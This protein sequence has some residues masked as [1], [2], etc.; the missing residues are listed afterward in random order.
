MSR[1][2]AHQGQYLCRPHAVAGLGHQTG[3]QLYGKCLKLHV[4]RLDVSKSPDRPNGGHQVRKAVPPGEQGAF[5][6]RDNQVDY[7]PRTRRDRDLH[8]QEKALLDRGSIGP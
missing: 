4:V 1:C 2:K 8:Q 6:S 7:S 5:R 3:S